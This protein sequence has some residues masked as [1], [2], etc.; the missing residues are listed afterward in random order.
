MLFT[1]FS[2]PEITIS[3][4]KAP[5]MH[6]LVYNAMTQYLLLNVLQ[7]FQAISGGGYK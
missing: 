1:I 3:A 4:M 7:W 5:Y 2:A 6:P